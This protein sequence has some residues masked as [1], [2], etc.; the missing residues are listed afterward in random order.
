MMWWN[1]GWG[2]GGWLGMTLLMLVFWGALIWLIS[3]L[4]GN[5]SGKDT[6]PL[7]R[8]ADVLAE[9]FARAEIGQAE[10]L[11]RLHV[12]RLH[13]LGGHRPA[14]LTRPGRTVGKRA[15]CRCG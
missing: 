14:R 1:F 3:T 13:H 9:R 5:G 8:A 2:W 12:P 6:P 11:D 10:Y 7:R 15:R 4:V